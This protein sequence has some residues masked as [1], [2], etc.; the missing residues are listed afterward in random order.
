MTS[1]SPVNYSNVRIYEG[2]VNL[3]ILQ[4]VTTSAQKPRISENHY[5]GGYCHLHYLLRNI[6]GTHAGVSPGLTLLKIPENAK[7]QIS[8]QS[9]QCNKILKSF[10]TVQDNSPEN[11]KSSLYF[12][13][14]SS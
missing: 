3:D 10:D 9:V 2:E 7:Q 11:N 12:I 4:P 14:T 13:H 6:T 5:T 1:S 8:H